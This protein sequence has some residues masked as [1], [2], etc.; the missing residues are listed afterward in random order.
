MMR[1]F[2]CKMGPRHCAC[3]LF[4]VALASGQ[5]S[6]PTILPWGSNSFRIQWAPPGLPIVNSTYSPFL[7]APLSA[8]PFT[9]SAGGGTFTNGNLALTVDA[10]TGLLTATRVSDGFTFFR[11]TGMEWAPPV[12]RGRFPSAQVSFDGHAAG[13][14]LVGGGEQG[15]TGRVVLEQPFSRDYIDSEY[16]GYNQGRQAFLPL[17]FSATAGWG[18]MYATPGYGSLRMDVAPYTSVLNSSSAATVELWL[19]TTPGTPALAAGAPHP[20]L[21]LL[22]QYADAVGHAPRMPAFASGFIASKD[23]YHNQTQFLEVAHG[24]VDRGIP[25]S[26]KFGA[27]PRQQPR[28]HTKPHSNSDP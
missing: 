1:V 24:Y 15:L 20:L 4:C 9:V 8:S 7:D 25:L 3:A 10:A 28:A 23:R 13:E 14:S 22:A 18:L 21:S 27:Q 2:F 17:V 16:Y 19:T 12:A 26:R 5:A 6:Q 11:Q